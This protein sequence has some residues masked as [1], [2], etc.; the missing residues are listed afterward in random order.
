VFVI[1]GQLAAGKSTVAR[2]ILAR[3][4][5]GLH[6]DVDAIREMVVAGLASP[7]E[8]TPETTRQ[9][10]IAIR[11]SVLLALTYHEEGFAVAIEG[12]VD[13]ESV[14]RAFREGAPGLS[15]T[16]IT[17]HPSLQVAR[18][19]NRARTTKPFDPGVLE[20]VMATIDADLTRAGGRTGWLTIDNGAEWVDET[21]DRIVALARGGA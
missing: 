2:A 5:T 18:A 11:A 7:L 16:G 19:R 15:F 17:L 9:F 14:E 12:A 6:V 8:W 10:E 20:D 21:V 4:P 3:Y 1:T 13:P